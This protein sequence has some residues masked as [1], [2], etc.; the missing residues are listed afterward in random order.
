MLANR[1]RQER[2]WKHLHPILH[3]LCVTYIGFLQWNFSEGLPSPL[4]PRPRVR[5]G[6]GVLDRK[7]LLLGCV[8]PWI[9]LTEPMMYR[10]NPMIVSLASWNGNN[11]LRYLL[12]SQ[13]PLYNEGETWRHDAFHHPG[14]SIVLSTLQ[15]CGW[16]P[17]LLQP[18]VLRPPPPSLLH[19]SIY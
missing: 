10:R 12:P 4:V 7:K 2:Y 18:S 15:G 3:S 19:N 11:S 13:S 5:Q 14:D 1:L 16:V 8:T 6:E 17:K 9:S